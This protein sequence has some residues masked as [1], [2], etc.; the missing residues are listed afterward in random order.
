MH[1]EHFKGEAVCVVT[2]GMCVGG[3]VRV[4]VEQE[5]EWGVL[6]KHEVHIEDW[7]LDV[8]AHCSLCPQRPAS[9]PQL[10]LSLPRHQPL[11]LARCGPA[12]ANLELPCTCSP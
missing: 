6:L 4:V 2:A 11:A 12:S 3:G 7:M 5:E 8:P 9:R 1:Q 10:T